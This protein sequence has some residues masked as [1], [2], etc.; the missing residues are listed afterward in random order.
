MKNL[1]TGKTLPILEEKHH[2]IPKYRILHESV[3]GA[4]YVLII[5]L[6]NGMTAILKK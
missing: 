5:R 1:Y 6:V 4:D 2:L 3:D